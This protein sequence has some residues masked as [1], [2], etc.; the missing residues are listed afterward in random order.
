MSVL[1]TRMTEHA[2]Q[3]EVKGSG[4]KSLRDASAPLPQPK[5]AKAD[6]FQRPPCYVL[7]LAN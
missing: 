4:T 5:D 3:I 2:R 6:Q 7:V 1:E